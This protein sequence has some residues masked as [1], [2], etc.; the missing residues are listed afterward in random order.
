MSIHFNDQLSSAALNKLYEELGQPKAQDGK[1]FLFDALPDP[2]ERSRMA[3]I[4][5]EAA[6]PM[7]T[8]L[9]S[10]GDIQTLEDG[11]QWR[12]TPNGWHKIMI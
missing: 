1:T 11:T 3:A 9:N 2:I 8:E 10:I 7:S 12:L 4:A 6:Q 5:R